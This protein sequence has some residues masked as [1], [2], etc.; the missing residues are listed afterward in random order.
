MGRLDYYYLIFWNYI[1]IKQSVYKTNNI[2]LEA[3]VVLG[4]CGCNIN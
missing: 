4:V 2:N 1:L 3:N